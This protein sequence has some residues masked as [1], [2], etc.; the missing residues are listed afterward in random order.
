MPRKTTVPR[1]DFPVCSPRSSAT[2]GARTP[3]YA[4]A[5]QWF[6]ETQFEAYR[7]LGYIGV[8]VHFVQK[9]A[10]FAYRDRTTVLTNLGRQRRVG[11]A[12]ALPA[13]S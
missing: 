7:K 11:I 4:R 1:N 2:S 3:R 9:V 8:T 5:V 12:T 13:A 6:D 10:I